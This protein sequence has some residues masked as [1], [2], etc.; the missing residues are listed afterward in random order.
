MKISA[1]SYSRIYIVALCLIALFTISSQVFVQFYLHGQ[2]SSSRVINI[3]GRQRMLSQKISKEA[4]LLINT[5]SNQAFVHHQQIL[6]ADLTIWNRSHRGL[7]SG[8][9]ALQ[10]PKPKP[11]KIIQKYFEEMH[12]FKHN[13]EE[14][15]QRLLSANFGDLSGKEK[16]LEQI[17]ES[18]K[19]FLKLMNQITFRFEEMAKQEVNNFQRVELFLMIFTLLLL[20]LE[21]LYI[22]RPTFRKIK[23]NIILIEENSEEIEAQNQMLSGILTKMQKQSKNIASS[24]K[25][26]KTIQDASLTLEP[27]VQA[28][29]DQTAFILF[30]PLQVV[31]GDFYYVADTPK[32][33][34]FAA[35]DCQG[36]GIPGAFLS[37]IGV[38]I[39]NDI[40]KVKSIIQPGEILNCLHQTVC[41]T[42][43]QETTN[44]RDSMDLALITVI[45]NSNEVLF[46][47][48][49]NP[50]IYVSDHQLYEIKGNRKA[51]G[52]R[53]TLKQTLFTTHT[54]LIDKTTTFYL[55]S[56]G[57]QDQF[58]G[59]ERRKFLKGRL[60]ELL[61]DLHSKPFKQHK[62]ALE[63][64]LVNWMNEGNQHQIDD[65]LVMGI[66]SHPI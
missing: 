45:K 21:G 22:F 62:L 36:H 9:P 18:E 25:Y 19:P 42:L 13:I 56:D 61:L 64:T 6:K 1:L 20:L 35:V 3:S 17:L 41:K 55:F 65:I 66:E 5:S 60:K 50:L 51:I 49:K 34:V 4:L 30:K 29:L 32:A 59:P 16:W 37:M 2:D 11:D 27:A 7:Q 46:A 38:A 33:T 58:G 52:G 26:A 57:F 47:G 39:L 40:V 8:D 14:A 54:V 48:A 23:D 43:R 53:S 24:I 10:L 12:P 63:Q 44:N 31:S 15:T 28:R